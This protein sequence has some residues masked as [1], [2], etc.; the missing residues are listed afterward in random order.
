MRDLRHDTPLV[1]VVVP[2]FNVGDRVADTI[3]S[4]AS[5][6]GETCEI[7][8]VNDGSTDDTSIRAREALVP[9]DRGVVVDQPNGG[10]SMARNTGLQYASGSLVHFLD[11]DDLLSGALKPAQIRDWVTERY[12]IVFFPLLRMTADLSSVRHR[13]HTPPQGARGE[14]L[15]LP[16]LQDRIRLSIVSALYRTA[17]LRKR[18]IRFPVGVRHC[19]DQFMMAH[20]IHSAQRTCVTPA[21]RLLYVQR[22]SSATATKGIDGLD[23]VFILRKLWRQLRQKAVPRCIYHAAREKAGRE[24]VRTYRRTVHSGGYPEAIPSERVYFLIGAIHAMRTMKY[25]ESMIGFVLAVLGTSQ[26]FCIARVRRRLVP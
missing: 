12:D 2:A 17:F 25:R 24:L 15:L 19:E 11:G 10:V 22:S 14:A 5:A 9:I 6:Y 7:I 13:Q 18:N 4:A 20:A 8:V 1:S 16:Y 23:A 26:A 21:I 3:A